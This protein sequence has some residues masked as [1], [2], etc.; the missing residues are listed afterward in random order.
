VVKLS[1]NARRKAYR[2]LAA[3]DPETWGRISAPWV[4]VWCGRVFPAPRERC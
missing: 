2:A 3:Q 1:K 4:S